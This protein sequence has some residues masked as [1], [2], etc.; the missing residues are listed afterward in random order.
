MHHDIESLSLNL[1]GLMPIHHVHVIQTSVVA[2]SF[3][4]KTSHVK[5]K[6][7]FGHSG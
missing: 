7:P 3:V 2:N 6:M 4:T 5:E 1:I